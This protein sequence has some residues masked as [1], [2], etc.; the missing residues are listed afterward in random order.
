MVA[1]MN[2][3]HLTFT[4]T[5]ADFI[6]G[7]RSVPLRISW[8]WIYPMLGFLILVLAIA[9]KNVFFAIFG[10]FFMSMNI[11][12]PVIRGIQLSRCPT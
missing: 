3:I 10:C 11:V 6:S 12:Y 7:A 1:L 8:A 2:T 4:Y 9:L 5:T